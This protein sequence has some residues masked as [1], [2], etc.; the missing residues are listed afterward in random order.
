MP[1]SPLPVAK[2]LVTI[3]AKTAADPSV[4]TE[5]PTDAIFYD[6]RFWSYLVATAR[7]LSRTLGPVVGIGVGGLQANKK[8]LV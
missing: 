6:A 8:A 4:L 3:H 7:T 1:R 5:F 2:A